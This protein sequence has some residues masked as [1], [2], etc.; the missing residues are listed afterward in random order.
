[1][2]Y[3]SDGASSPTRPYLQLAA[4]VGIS[5]LSV[6]TD[7]RGIA[8]D[9]SERKACEASCLSSLEDDAA[10]VTTCL[11]DCAATPIGVY[12]ANRSPASL[13]VGTTTANAWA[14]TNRDVPLFYD[15]VPLPVGPSRLYVGKVVGDS[16][17][18]ETRVFVVCF[19]QRRIAIYDP[20]RRRVESFVT[21]GQG[22]HAL[23]F[24]YAPAN[25][26]AG[27]PARALAYVAHFTESYIGV[28][29]LDRR[30]IRTYANIVL[31][32]GSAVAPR[33]SK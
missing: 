12:V 18:L 22:P 13:L 6:G 3:Y 31:N 14:T 4:R 17:L 5:A 15:T 8:F 2:R 11:Q 30:N 24:D 9:D 21:T 23:A 33:A 10:A 1:L 16:G 29:E 27:T 26:S 19:D 32:L 7:S 28:I 20:V 25:E